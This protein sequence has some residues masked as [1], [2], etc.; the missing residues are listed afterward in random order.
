[1]EAPHGPHRVVWP[2]WV[3]DADRRSNSLTSLESE[4]SKFRSPR[5]SGPAGP[6]FGAKVGAH[7]ALAL[8]AQTEACGLLYA[9]MASINS[10]LPVRANRSSPIPLRP[11]R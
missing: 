6:Q 7:Y 11:S 8:L 5:A 3:L 1:M 4:G 9:G 2:A 10:T